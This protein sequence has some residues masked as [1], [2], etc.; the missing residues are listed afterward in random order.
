MSNVRTIKLQEIPLTYNE[1]YELW[2]SIY[3]SRYILN[4]TY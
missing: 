4:Q 2:N 1:K 3:Y